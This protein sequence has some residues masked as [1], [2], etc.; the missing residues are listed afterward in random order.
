[1][2]SPL[3]ATK[4]QLLL[5]DE[6]FIERHQGDAKSRDLREMSMAHRRS[7][8]LSLEAYAVQSA[9]RNHGMVLAYQSGAY[10]MAQIAEYF[11]VHYRTVSRIVR[12]AELNL[13]NDDK[14]TVF[15]SSYDRFK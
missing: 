14:T 2:S 3:E 5:G 6:Q 1:M 4:H 12:A 9:N 8:A 7:L 10:T 13:V 11:G 15:S